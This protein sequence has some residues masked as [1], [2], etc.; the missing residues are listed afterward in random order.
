MGRK[1]VVDRT[2]Q[3]IFDTLVA[4]ASTSLWF[5]KISGSGLRLAH[6]LAQ[7]CAETLAFTLLEERFAYTD[8]A[9]LTKIFGN[10]L[11]AEQEKR[12]VARDEKTRHK[13][14]KAA[15]IKAKQDAIT[16]ATPKPKTPAE[17]AALD[18]ALAAAK[19][20]TAEDLVALQKAYAEADKAEFA[21]RIELANTVYGG[22]NGNNQPGDGYR[23]RGRGLL[24]LTF[25]GNYKAAG[26]AL[27]L[28]LESKPDMVAEPDTALRTAVWYWEQNKL[29]EEADGDNVL[30][31][32]KGVNCGSPNSTSEP[33]ALED[34]K[35]LTK[36]AKEI[37]GDRQPE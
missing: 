12:F 19:T 10:Y 8:Q 20:L 1:T 33:N 36:L 37:W 16:K 17:Q 30:R 28:P 11:T 23:F 35:K 4:A 22:R 3:Q 2:Q 5:V 7:C 29:N 14:A 34:R 24:H 15:F 6:F 27:S 31:V 26:S 9:R 21:M 32:S 13:D 18:K 25:R